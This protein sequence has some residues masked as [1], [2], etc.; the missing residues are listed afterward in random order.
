TSC[1]RSGTSSSAR[2]PSTSSPGSSSSRAAH[3]SREVS[4]PAVGW[5]R[6]SRA[7]TTLYHAGL[8]ARVR[9]TSMVPRRLDKDSGSRMAAGLHRIRHVD[10][11]DLDAEPLPQ[12]LAE[13]AESP[14]FRRVMASGEVVDS[15]CPR[16]VH[17]PLAHLA[18]DVGVEALVDG[19]VDVALR[20]AADDPQG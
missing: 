2:R 1:T 3:S 13:G 6:A 15:C 20:T 19:G 11:L 12:V 9:D 18:R 16:H 4:V 14:P 8:R 7:T 10:E 17:H 5:S